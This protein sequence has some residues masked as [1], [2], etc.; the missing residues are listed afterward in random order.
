MPAPTADQP[1]ATVLP[2]LE[3]PPL[4]Q[5]VSQRAVQWLVAL[6]APKVSDATRDAWRRW[7]D[8]HPDHER[9]WRHIESFGVQLRELNG[10]LASA[11]LAH[12]GA[13]RRRRTALKALAL[14]ALTGGGA[15][16]ARDGIRREW[17][18]LRAD[19]HTA[20]GQRRAFALADASRIDLDTDSAIDVRFDSAQRLVRLLRGRILVAT[21]P[22][23]A[24]DMARPARPFLVETPQA[25]LRALGTRFIVRQD[26]DGGHLA[27][28]EG[29]VEIR[30]LGAPQAVRVIAAGEQAGFDRDGVAA[31]LAADPQAGAWSTG[32]LVARDMRLD[33][34]IAELSRYRHGRLACDPAAASL[35]VSGI[36]PLDDSERVLDMLQRTL[37]IDVHRL[38]RYWITLRLRG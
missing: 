24:E 22:D 35:K 33:D 23:P 14:A 15:W 12:G 26:A 11:T 27:V 4:P 2:I 38:N 20:I 25:R 10:P 32:M 9:A 7:R 29:A 8:E 6:Q 28:L 17:Q 34:F 36:Y 19:H 31:P 18:D 1:A 5:Q 30:P 21:A 16:L 3:G 37:P 13:S